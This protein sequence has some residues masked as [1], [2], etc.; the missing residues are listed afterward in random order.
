MLGQI[1][2]VQSIREGGDDGK[3]VALNQD[4][5]TGIAF[6]KL[7]DNLVEAIDKRNRDLPK[8]SIVEMKVK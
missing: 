3:P 1:P 8:T 6:S 5:I 4:S 7:A 2:I